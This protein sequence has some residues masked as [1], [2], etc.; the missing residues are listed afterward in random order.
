MKARILALSSRDRAEGAARWLVQRVRI[1]L[2]A[3]DGMS[4]SAIAERV[5]VSRPTVIG[6][7][8]RYQQRGVTGLCDEPRSGRPRMVDHRAVVAATLNPPPNKL[9]VTHWSS[10][11][12]ADRLGIGNATVARAWRRSGRRSC[13]RARNPGWCKNGWPPSWA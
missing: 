12:L 4:N 3:A 13:W 1:V 8:S 7:R 2:L 9:G 6:W 5:G 10:R 11:L